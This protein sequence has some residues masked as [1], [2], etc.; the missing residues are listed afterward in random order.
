MTIT[1]HGQEFKSYQC[2]HRGITGQRCTCRFTDADDMP[3]HMARHDATDEACRATEW[4][5]KP[6]MSEARKMAAER[7]RAAKAILPRGVGVAEDA[8]ERQKR[9]YVRKK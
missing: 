8:L 5:K 7:M 3:L 1:S 4:Q 9:Y 6:S 2:Q